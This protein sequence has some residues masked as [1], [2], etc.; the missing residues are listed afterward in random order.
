MGI[1]YI[2][3]ENRLDDL[4]ESYLKKMIEGMQIIPTEFVEFFH[5]VKNKTVLFEISEV[6]TDSEYD[7]G[8]D[9]TLYN[10][11]KSIF[12]LSDKKISK[13]IFRVIE[14]ITD[15]KFKRIYTFKEDEPN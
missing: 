8:V 2:I 5:Y 9:K 1:K 14:E 7:L 4:A 11:F 6:G 3:N 10:Q 12:G 13:I 15:R